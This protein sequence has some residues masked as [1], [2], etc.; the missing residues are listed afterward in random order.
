MD[1][2]FSRSV[3]CYRHLRFT[4]LQPGPNSVDIPTQ[5]LIFWPLVSP[6]YS[7]WENWNIDK[8]K[9][10]EP[11]PSITILTIAFLQV[12]SIRTWPLVASL[13]VRQRPI[14]SLPNNSITCTIGGFKRVDSSVK[15]VRAPD[16]IKFPQL[17][18]I[19]RTN[20]QCPLAPTPQ[21][22]S[23]VLAWPRASLQIGW[24]MGLVL[25]SILS[26]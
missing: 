13:A 20:L 11:W 2:R 22:I 1:R 17:T 6:P 18:Y 15:I 4:F 24:S 26:R 3:T 5:N 7:W 19:G 21:S 16:S 12:Q 10:A 14:S 9:P 23:P 25:L 8:G